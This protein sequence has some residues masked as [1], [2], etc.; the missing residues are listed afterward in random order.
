MMT[1][2]GRVRGVRA[3]LQGN[4]GR[5][6]VR[7][8]EEQ[9]ESMRGAAAEVERSEDPNTVEGNT[10][11][12]VEV[13]GDKVEQVAREKEGDESGYEEGESGEK[14][15]GVGEEHRLESS[16][17]ESGKAV[18]RAADSSEAEGEVS[19]HESIKPDFVVRE[20]EGEKED[21]YDWEIN[22]NENENCSTEG[23]TA[24]NRSWAEE[25][26]MGFFGFDDWGRLSKFGEDDGEGEGVRKVPVEGEVEQTREAVG[27][28]GSIEVTDGE[29]VAIPKEAE[30]SVRPKEQ[31]KD[32]KK[33]PKKIP[34]TSTRE[35]R[36]REARELRRSEL[37]RREGCDEEVECEEVEK[38]ECGVCKETI[39]EGMVEC[40]VCGRW[41]CKSCAELESDDEVDDVEDATEAT[42][43]L[44]ACRDCRENI[45][46]NKKTVKSLQA[47]LNCRD[48][49]IEEWESRGEEYERRI[50]RK[51]NTILKLQ[52]ENEALERARRHA[53][54]ECNRKI[55]EAK[56]REQ[57]LA[58]EREG[59][60]QEKL[61]LSHKWSDVNR[62]K[63]INEAKELHFK[64]IENE[65]RDFRNKISE[66]EG[67]VKKARE[68]AIFNSADGKLHF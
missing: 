37:L 32:K 52:R 14:E 33:K 55:M 59:I 38:S 40:D 45:R 63:S 44:F 12:D 20:E 65:R 57:G 31:T 64:N 35:L 67:E 1:R 50:D 34:E 27:Q 22:Y 60:K 25:S 3:G 17:T 36:R 49:E 54:D 42:G 61:C 58:Q 9:D 5:G 11:G 15:D 41:L 23:V 18:G 56:M 7:G 13:T 68:G 21:E 66:L 16:D 48:R 28:T 62:Q 4:S 10:E 30:Q 39:E 6:Q 19:D 53:V 46:E 29:A 8:R 2:A 26:E 43:I 51:D 24:L 47:S